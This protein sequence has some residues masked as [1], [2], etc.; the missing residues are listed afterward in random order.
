MNLRPSIVGRRRTWVAVALVLLV[1][2]VLI[3]S[4][5][6]V[7]VDGYPRMASYGIVDQRTIVVTVAVSPRSWTRVTSVAETSTEVRVTVE[8]LDWPIPLPGTAELDLQDLTVSLAQDLGTR[9]VRDADGR[10]ILMIGIGS[11]SP[12]QPRPALPTDMPSPSDAAQTAGPPPLND[13][14]VAVIDALAELGLTGMR[15]E[16]PFANATSAI[17]VRGDDG[18]DLTISALRI[19]SDRSDFVVTGTRQSGGIGVQMDDVSVSYGENHRF[20]C[21][22]LRYYVGGWTQPPFADLDA[23][24]DA[25]IG[26]IDCT[27]PPAGT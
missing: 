26:V 14:E 8:S 3:R 12:T 13:L 17:W 23:L 6:T 2:V 4:N 5:A 24:I 7:F 11:P 25:F 18:R 20:H 22:D 9:A 27:P 1:A 10:A 16:L 15:A 19:D 21:G